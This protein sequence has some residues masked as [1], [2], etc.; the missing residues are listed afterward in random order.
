[1]MDSPLTLSALLRHTERLHSAREIVSRRADRSLHRYTYRECLQQ[2]RRLA[3]A[4]RGLGMR[5]G[6]RIATFA[7][8]H[9][10]HLEAYF[11]TS[12]SGLVLHT[13]NLRL[14]PDD[15]A[16]IAS[17]A[18][19]RVAI[20]DDV[21]WPAFEKFA[22]RAP[23]EHVIVITEDGAAPAG[24]LDYDTLLAASEP[25]P[26]PDRLD[27]YA[28]ASRCYTSGTTGKPKGV[29]YSHRSLVLHSMGTIIPDVM[30]LS[31]TDTILPVVPMFHANAWGAP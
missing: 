29:V 22:A 10:R 3:A 9:H 7:W 18:G 31:C 17:D 25:E 11:G 21:L 1:M 30:D 8:N 5:P 6:D 13:L 27:E 23:F 12:A 15:L 20:V 26:C 19:D 14:H 2:A 16:F 24:T 28:A 4:L